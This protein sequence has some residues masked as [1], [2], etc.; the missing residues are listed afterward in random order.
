MYI[1]YIFKKKF[2]FFQR[3]YFI[4]RILSSVALFFL[5][6][7]VFTDR[8]YFGRDKAYKLIYY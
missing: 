7:S 3:K 4:M 2:A 1:N 8:D 6:C 5:Y